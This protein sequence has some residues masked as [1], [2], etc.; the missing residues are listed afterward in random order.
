MTARALLQWCPAL[1]VSIILILTA[2]LT[3]EAPPVAVRAIGEINQQD[4][5]WR[6]ADKP[7]TLVVGEPNLTQCRLRLELRLEPGARQTTELVALPTDASNLKLAAA[8][9]FTLRRDNDGRLLT[10]VPME[11]NPEKGA[12]AA[13]RATVPLVFW[14]DEKYKAR[15]DVAQSSGLE[16]KTWHGRWLK[17]RVDVEARSM[18][19]WLEGRL[20][21]RIDRPAGARGPLALLLASGDSVRGATIEPIT[22]QDRFLPIDLDAY[23]NRP[24]TQP[25]PQPSA[26]HPILSGDVPFALSGDPYGVLDLSGAHWADWKIDPANYREPYDGGPSFL[27]DM[28]MPMLRVP[29]ADYMAAHI[30]AVA[31]DDPGHVPV[32]TLRA[33]RYGWNGQTLQHDFPATVPRAGDAKGK[34]PVVAE[35]P[36]G[37]LF[38]VRVPMTE[39]FAQDINDYLE[40]ELTK[41]VRL[42]RRQDDA[43]RFRDRPLGL[44]SGVRIAA[45]TFEK[46]PLQ[47]RVSSAESGHAF[48]EPQQPTFSVQLTNITDKAQDYRLT[49]QA[50]PIDG[51]ST[52]AVKAGSVA[53]GGSETVQVPLPVQARGY[54]DL[55]VTLA[56]GQGNA[57]LR[58]RT[59]C[60][61]LPRDT[62]KHRDTSPFGTWDFYGGHYTCSDP[63]KLGPLYVKLGL[64]YG[65]FNATTEAL[66]KYGVIFGGEPKVYDAKGIEIYEQALK[67][68]PGYTPPG[69]IFHE[70]SISRPH[71]ARTPDL[72]TDRPP[73]KLNEEEEISF[74]RLW[75]MA[76]T[77]ARAMRDKHPTAHLRFGNGSLSL[78]EE[79][80]RRGFPAELFD[81]A[82]NESPSGMRMPE[83][84]PPDSVANNSS[85][86]MDRQLLDAYGYRDKPVTQCY[87]ICYPG[88]NP[89]NLTERTQ[90]DYLV[91]HA[92]HSLAWGMPQIKLGMMTDVGNAYYF[93][94]YGAAGFCRAMPEMSVKP[95]FV[96]FATLTRVLDGAKFVRDVPTGSASLYLL[97]FARPEGGTAYVLWTVRGER[98]MVLTVGPGAWTLV[99]AQGAESALSAI[100]GVVTVAA[101]PTPVYLIGAGRVEKVAPGQPVYADQPQGKVSSLSPLASMDEWQVEAGPNAE[102]ETFNA[103]NPRR[104]GNFA[105][106]SEESFEGKEG[107]LKVAPR[108]IDYGK[109]T[110]PMYAVLAHKKGISIP[111]K[112]T[113]VGLWINGNSGWGRVIFEFKDASGQRWISIGTESTRMADVYHV[114]GVSGWHGNDGFGVSRI[115]FDGWRYVGFPMPGNYPG[116]GYGWPANSQWR[117]ERENVV[118]YPLTLTKLIVELPEKTLHMKDYAPVPRPEIYLKDLVTCEGAIRGNE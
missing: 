34:A 28:R 118:H 58:R 107:V 47:M 111:G 70:N 102:L 9:R 33:G 94:G 103:L 43:V 21:H 62:R 39:T 67:R 5:V 83:T 25:S 11:F 80:F 40:I 64:R 18:S 27:D 20:V 75:D 86:W 30:L 106:T 110:M 37:P 60:A 112:P 81:S 29:S 96:S 24:A 104:L 19:F 49:A 44:P 68:L 95:S 41:E 38:H 32:V 16:P 55:T 90:A 74:K 114:P 36:A 12:W 100:D 69:L 23:I 73:H 91:R 108:P 51:Q 115:N 7:A 50:M 46:S 59:S 109:A 101:S 97:E 113:E 92:L 66:Q 57:W 13:A 98:S 56:D 82:G 89:G 31:D 77:S 72:F 42:A 17:L 54:Y 65:M 26:Q 78:K 88:T 3:A 45:I 6:V 76:T 4:G 105:F 79:F 63:D 84:Q 117:W 71:G 15:L 116:E 87:E 1:S 99:N 53:A 93:S 2:P 52:Q 61:L 48:E 85:L 35:S 10:V 22:A 14:P 8:A